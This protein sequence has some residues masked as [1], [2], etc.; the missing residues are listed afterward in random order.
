MRHHPQAEHLVAE[1]YTSHARL[2]I[3]GRSAGGLLIGAVVT[4]R[5]ELFHAAIAGV[6]FVDALTTMLD[7]SIPLTIVEW[8]EWGQPRDPEFY[9]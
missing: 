8:E 3:E 4:M 5:P 2:C 1:S 9:A 7:E 6:P